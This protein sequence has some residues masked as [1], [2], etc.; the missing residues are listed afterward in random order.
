MDETV[1]S[2]RSADDDRTMP[3]SDDPKRDT[4]GARLD[5]DAGQ[6]TWDLLAGKLESLI[7]RWDNSRHPPVLGEFVPQG[8]PSLRRLVLTELIKVDLDYRWQRN[9]PKMIEDYAADFPEICGPNGVPCDLIFEEFQV[10][11][12]AGEP[13]SAGDYYN[14]FPAQAKELGRLL[15]VDLPTRVTLAQHAAPAKTLK[16]GDQIDDFDL[17]A[18]IGEGAFAKVFLAR[19]RSMQRLVAL[20]ISADK[21]AEPQTLAQLDH[22]HIVRVHD[23]RVISDKG[24][25][26]L[27][28]PY[29]P[30][31]TLHDVL[32]QIRKTPVH[33][34]SGKTLLQSVDENLTKRGE[35]VPLESNIRQRIAGMTW[36]ET[37]CWLGARLAEALH[38]A[39]ERGVLHR[40]VKPANVLLGADAAPRLADFNVGWSSK[41]DG[42]SPAA[43]FGGSIGYM[44]PEQLEAFNPQH[45]RTP[46]SL[47][48]R[49]DI[50]A[51]GITLWELLTGRRPFTDEQLENEWSAT[52]GT[53]TSRRKAGVPSNVL[54][55]L[56]AD[57]PPGMR[58]VLLKCLEPDPDDRYRTAAKVAR[59]LELCLKPHT[60]ELLYPQPGWRTWARRHPLI[61]L[62]TVGLV[63]NILASLFSIEYNQTEIVNRVPEAQKMFEML[64]WIVNPTFFPAGIIAFFFVARPIVRA[65]KLAREGKGT[66]E[67]FARWR[68]QS[69]QLGLGAMLV[70]LSA[71]VISA[72]VFP[73]GLHLTVHAMPWKFH[74][75]FLASQTL[76]GLI[77]VTYPLF[78]GDQLVIRAIYPAFVPNGMLTSDD[79]EQL[80][81]FEKRI[82]WQLLLA[83]IMPPLALGLLALSETQ[84]RLALSVLAAA[85]FA[86]VTVAYFLSRGIRTDLAA[87]RELA[88]ER[89]RS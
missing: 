78:G 7:Q 9:A 64:M 5:V 83:A 31:G 3:A 35:V 29:I 61:V 38:Y 8:S 16:A 22:P 14:R 53:L 44:S 86:G 80:Q 63:P 25:R 57:L 4:S 6:P 26:L 69:L 71:W 33:Q 34:R 1:A 37:V 77:A 36:A 46:A 50:Y 73:V 59:Q 70:C 27:Y 30:G 65:L 40:D 55:T 42:V 62:Y 49:S 11:K 68:R 81:R 75:H 67:D 12:R 43:F 87:L 39:H 18:L 54:A 48:A 89:A 32:Q 58:D 76:C 41:L 13:V 19:Q 85:G 74:T 23:Q 10:R 15:G 21:G 88:E 79:L 24:I 28:M 45:P 82:G 51:L 20:K 72:V 17:L 84:N 66:A 47:D 56:P 52:I 60:R 2:S